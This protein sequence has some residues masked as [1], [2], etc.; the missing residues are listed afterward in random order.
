LSTQDLSM[1]RRTVREFASRYV[2]PLA[3]RI[4]AENWYPRELVRDMGKMGDFNP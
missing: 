1:L 4:D 2:A 3:K